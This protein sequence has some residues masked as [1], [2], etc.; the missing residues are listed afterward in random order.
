M[1][2]LGDAYHKGIGIS[3]AFNPEISALQV[4]IKSVL[5]NI[6]LG[7]NPV[8]DWRPSA[9]SKNTACDSVVAS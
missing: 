3:L 8:V 2:T 5:V 4:H 6:M 9:E 7:E 1:R